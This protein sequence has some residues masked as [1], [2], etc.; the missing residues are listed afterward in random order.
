MGGKGK[1]GKGKGK[2][3][4]GSSTGASNFIG[5]VGGSKLINRKCFFYITLVLNFLIKKNST[6]TVPI[7]TVCESE[8]LSNFSHST[9]LSGSKGKGKGKRPPGAINDRPKVKGWD[10]GKKKDDKNDADDDG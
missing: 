2:G 7:A 1:P 5:G 10:A 8:I 3:K 9:L 4:G 6:L